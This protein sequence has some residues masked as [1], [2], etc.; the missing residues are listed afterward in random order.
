MEPNVTAAGNGGATV[1]ATQH[2]AG[3]G[4]EY[5]EEEVRQLV[6]AL[7][8][9]FDP[10]DIKWRV[11][12]MTSDRRRGQMMAYADPRAYTDRLNELFTVRGWTRE[13]SVEAITNVERKFSN[14][15]QIAGK[16]VV[17]CRLTIH[18]LG[19][20]SGIGE[21]WADNENAGT[22]AE[23]QAFK[24]ACSCFGLGRY[25]YDLEGGWVDLDDRKQPMRAP[26]LPD[27]A[28]PKRKQADGTAS[29][30]MGQH[31][32]RTHDGATQPA[33]AAILRTNIKSLSG[34]VGYSL[35]RSVLIGVAKAEDAEKIASTLLPAV[36][37]KLE[38]TLRGVERLRRA[39]AI[40]GQQ[41]YSELCRELNFASDALDDIP[42]RSAL[43]RLIEAL[44]KEVGATASRQGIKGSAAPPT[45]K[46]VSEARSQLLTEAQR[47][48][49]LKGMKVAEVV[50]RAAKGAFAY[51]RLHRVTAGDL[52]AI[53]AATAVLRRVL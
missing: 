53:Q 25:L 45:A 52:P 49:R 13:Y 17:T 7:D 38:D 48:A 47:V 34:Q 26:K 28:I 9:P 21:E 42:D 41:R 15:S 32:G 20:H 31:N 50:D 23:A 10:R 37:S 30:T 46:A 16:V 39:T 44:E 3:G 43:R 1:S 29:P 14:G 40:V 11:T 51:S 8:E 33:E 35:S 4:R 36:A 24:R 5:T 27:W 12:N 6:A 19:A 2:G 18:G 22:A